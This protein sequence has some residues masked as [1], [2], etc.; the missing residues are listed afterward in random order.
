MKRIISLALAVIMV[1]T[2]FPMT[3][4]AAEDSA[5]VVQKVRGNPGS[6]VKVKIDLKNSAA[7][8]ASSIEIFYDKSVLTLT[9][10]EFGS[11]FSVGNDE[12]HYDSMPLTLNWANPDL[13][14]TV[15]DGTYAILAFTIDENAIVNQ[16]SEI[17]VKYDI[18]TTNEENLIFNIENGGVEII[19]GIP[20][21]INGD[22]NVNMNDLVRMRKVLAKWPVDADMTAMDINGDG[23]VNM[24]DLVRFRKYLAKWPVEIFYGKVSS[25]KCIH[26]MR[27]FAARA[28]SC[29]EAGNLAYWMCTKCLK[30]FADELGATEIAESSIRIPA[31][32][33]TYVEIPAV[34]PTINAPGSTQGWKCGVCGKILSNPEPIPQLPPKSAP[35]VYVI[36]GTDRYLQEL[37]ISEKIPHPKRTTYEYGTVTYLDDTIDLSA[38]GYNFAGWFDAPSGGNRVYSIPADRTG[39]VTVYAHWDKEKYDVVYKTYQTPIEGTAPESKATFTSEKGLQD[40]WKPTLYNYEFLGWYD[41]N[42]N[43][44][45]SIPV[46]TAH[47]IT[48]NAYWI[49][50]RNRT[51]GKKNY[52]TP[53]VVEDVNAGTIYFA[54][55][56]G[57]I[58]NIPLS[59]TPAWTVQSVYGLSQKHS[60]TITT[61]ISN[62]YSQ[63]LASTISNSTTDSATWTLA[64]EWNESTSV[65]SEWANQHFGSVEEAEESLKTESGTWS[66]VKTD[67]S[68]TTD[69]SDT[70]TTTLSYDSKNEK[71]GH[72]DKY[73]AELD[74]KG[75]Y[76]RDSVFDAITIGKLEVEAELDLSGEWNVYNSSDK[77][78]GT[79]TTEYDTNHHTDSTNHSTTKTNST[80]KTA[81]EKTAVNRTLS[82]TIS[83]KTGYGQSYLNKE[84]NG[85]TLGQTSVQSDTFSTSTTINYS[86]TEQ[87]T[88]SVEYSVDGKYEGYYRCVVAG[89]AHVFGVVGYDIGTRSFFTYTL[90]IMDDNVHDFLDYSTSSSFNDCEYGVLPFEVPY[91][92]YNYVQYLTVETEGLEYEYNYTNRTAVLTGYNGH[93][94]ETTIVIPTYT[95]YNDTAFA[96]VGMAPGVFKNNTV[97]EDVVFSEYITKIPDETFLG[98]TNLRSFKLSKLIKEVGKDAFLGVKS[99]SVSLGYYTSDLTS[100]GLLA[101]AVAACGANAV[102]LDISSL[103]AETRMN[104]QTSGSTD[105]ITVRGKFIQYP[106]LTVH[107]DADTVALIGLGFTSA[108]ESPIRLSG[109][110]VTLNG[111]EIRDS[112]TIGMILSNPTTSLTLNGTNRVYSSSQRGIL[113]RSIN[114]Q[115]VGGGS[116]ITN[117]NFAYCG[118]LIGRTDKVI[119]EGE[120]NFQQIDDALYVSYEKGS[121]Y[122]T[123]DA[124][125]TDNPSRKECFMGIIVGELPMPERE[126]YNFD[127][128]F[129]EEGSA[130]TRD[131]IFTIE[132]LSENEAKEI[133]AFAHWSVKEYSL[134]WE[135]ATGCSITVNRISSPVAGAA[136]GTISAGSSVYYGDIINVSYGNL[137]GYSLT[138][139][140]ETEITVLTDVTAENIF[141]TASLIPYT[142]TFG[143]GEHYSVT[144]S[145]TSSPNAGAEVGTLGNNSTIYYG[146]TLEVSYSVEDGFLLNGHGAESITVTGNVDASQIYASAVPAMVTYRSV[147]YSTNGTYLGEGTITGQYG[148]SSWIN[149]GSY[150]GYASQGQQVNWDSL[151]SKDVVFYHTPNGVANFQY[152]AEGEWW[153]YSDYTYIAY[154]VAAETSNRTAN[155]IDVRIYWK[156][157]IVGGR[158]GY[159][160]YFSTS[161]NG[162]GFADTQICSNATWNES[163]TGTRSRE[164]YSEWKTIPVS[165]TQTSLYIGGGYWDQLRSGSWGNT[166]S[167]PAY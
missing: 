45:T 119:F 161:C 106:N 29:E 110:N 30:Y 58:E 92:I 93:P 69:V 49:S 71:D 21:D 42:G 75:K 120:A 9:G 11:A 34:E 95:I 85:Q 64:K 24:N 90:S 111:V 148:T 141:A 5:I 31:A 67:G 59:E 115:S 135:N 65:N 2:M 80:T 73:G 158:Y 160:Q 1:L 39:T 19:D 27:A 37:D 124:Q 128:W 131:T 113:S 109:S 61:T 22:G 123:F 154:S 40:L 152:V 100:A 116:L 127:G 7:F 132:D 149:P 32:G 82:E 129:T 33:H 43:E 125:G 26:T 162:V 51:V 118:E 3:V 94:E 122:L 10:H 167:I 97:I 155:S 91:D 121:Y 74:I 150:S 147:D 108:L 98:C 53:Y 164:V 78:T 36:T 166:I 133:T 13:N 12:P 60:E 35:I 81:S 163:K 56:I 159:A 153:R 126:G 107:S 4:L 46:G 66:T 23:N 76:T 38:Y 136:C 86:K 48:L 140:G 14:D 16:L 18:T 83:E 88:T 151:S 68:V 41:E 137:P 63:V 103:P 28:E 55:E 47:D 96:V 101:E 6:T 139:S 102:Y 105:D 62:S 72:D 8:F 77:H 70:G 165:A 156:S 89:T 143:N 145:R 114:L 112:K 87:K 84:S 17:T 104:L 99:V 15:K 57:T 20:G 54:Y 79:D 146:D 52:G 117:A 142:V 134:N 50:K 25:T 130:I 138:G 144:V 157:S 44:V